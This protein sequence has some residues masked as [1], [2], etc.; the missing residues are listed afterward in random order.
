[1]ANNNAKDAGLEAARRMRTSAV[2]C[3]KKKE[4]KRI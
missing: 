1:M 4:K 2:S 3:A